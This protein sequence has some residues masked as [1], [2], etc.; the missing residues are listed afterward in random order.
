MQAFRAWRETRRNRREESFPNLTPRDWRAQVLNGLLYTAAGLGF[1]AAGSGALTALPDQADA[2]IAVFVGALAVILALAF[3]RKMLP[4][5][6]RAVGLLAIAYFLAMDSLRSTALPGSGR[7]FLFAFCL[8]AVL[9]FGLRGGLV[10]L[11][12][13]LLSV[14]AVA[15]GLASGAL[16]F[17]G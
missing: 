13:S 3:L 11:V 12:V 4:F 8:I 7:V 2:G 10:A 6:I 14:A 15:W 17:S 1:P 16:P 5:Q 9:L